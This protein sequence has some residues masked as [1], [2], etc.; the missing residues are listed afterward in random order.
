V[1]KHTFNGEVCADDLLFVF[2]SIKQGLHLA[3]VRSSV[4]VLVDLDIARA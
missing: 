3:C 1:V 4:V 2:I